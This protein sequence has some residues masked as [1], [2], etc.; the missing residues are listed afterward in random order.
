MTRYEDENGKQMLTIHGMREMLR[1]KI[2][3]LDIESSRVHARAELWI[4]GWARPII[5]GTTKDAKKRSAVFGRF[6]GQILAVEAEKMA[7]DEYFQ[8]A[9]GL[10]AL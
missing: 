2:A 5:T 10:H 1:D 3:R 9:T 7:Y 8:R 4:K 6:P